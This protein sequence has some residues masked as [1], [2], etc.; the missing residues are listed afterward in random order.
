MYVNN[1][2]NKFE[3]KNVYHCQKSK[4]MIK[5]V[6]FNPILLIVIICQLIN[7]FKF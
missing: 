6:K 1:M 4:Q 7:S 2:Y 5:H 3:N